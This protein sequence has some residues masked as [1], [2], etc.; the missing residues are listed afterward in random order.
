[1]D[2]VVKIGRKAGLDLRA[3]RRCL[4][5]PGARAALDAEVAE[6]NRLGVD[7]TPSVYVNGKPLERVNDFLK[8]VDREARRQGF[9]P[10]P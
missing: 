3:F 10:V 7:S 4:E 6:A 2:D 8:V 1:M 9:S 5:D